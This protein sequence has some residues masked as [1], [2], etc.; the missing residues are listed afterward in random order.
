MLQ[1]AK[2]LLEEGT[3]LKVLLDTLSDDDWTRE[4]TFKNWTINH[5]IQHLHG[6]DRMAMLSLSGRENFTAV[7]K[8]PDQ[9]KSS[10]NPTVTGA[11]LLDQWWS[12]FTDMCESLGGSD[13]NRRLAWFGPDMGVKMF[14]TARQMET[15]AHGQEIYDLL[16]VKR[17]NSNRIK[18]IAVIGVRTYG[19]TFANRQ[20][21]PPG[22]PPYV[23]LTSP[24]GDL[25]E[26]NDPSDEN[27]V[28]G[29]AVEFCHVV[30]QGRN[31][32]DVKL[33]V[34]GEP[35]RQWMEIA[36]CFAGPPENPPAPGSRG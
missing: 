7:L 3:E 23:R 35:A 21:E 29:D 1:Q 34:V 36:Q 33:R 6:A 10:M 11:P 8:D 28:V 27:C 9:V 19:W 31:I 26:F 16:E 13:E 14:T 12:Y 18:N 32:R 22:P 4:T 25:W 30:T 17:V 5:V 15:W 24:V 2:D 20:M